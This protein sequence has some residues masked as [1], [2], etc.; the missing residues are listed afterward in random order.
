VERPRTI[1]TVTHSIE[2]GLALADKVVILANGRVGYE[3][4][5]KDMTAAEFRPL[6]DLYSLP[7][8]QAPGNWAEG[9]R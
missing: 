6:Y 3:A 2:R 5:V 8:P 9:G 7:A 4:T 1:V